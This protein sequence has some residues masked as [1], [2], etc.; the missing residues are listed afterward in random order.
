MNSKSGHLV[1]TETLL[2]ALLGLSVFVGF[3]YGI[4]S[5]PLFDLDEGAFAEATRE[6]FERG[7]FV[8]TYLNGV[9]RY[10]K[11]ILIYWLQAASVAL[12]GVNE[13][14]FRL[15]S[16]LAA[17][18]WVFLVY[19]FVA[20]LRD[21]RTG[22]VAA[23]MVATSLSI[24]VIGKAA[25]ADALLNMLLSASM[26]GAYIYLQDRDRRYLYATF[27]AVGLGFLTKG[28]VAI[29]IPVAVTF[30]YCAVRRELRLWL[31]TVF[32]L[33]GVTL[34]LAIAL[35]WYVLQYLKEGEAFIQGFFLKHNVSRF[36]SPMEGHG[37]GVFYYVPVV[38]F[39]VMPYTTPV[40]K[41]LGRFRAALRDDL[42]LYLLIW[43]VF[44]FAFFSLSGTKLPHYMNYGY[45]G[46]LIL[47]ALSVAELR[48]RFWALLPP[49]VC[50]FALA[51]LPWII[52]WALPRVED[53]FYREGLS[54]AG[55]YFTGGYRAYFFAAIVLTLYFM[56]ERRR[57]IPVKLLAEGI[58]L[59]FGV[60]AFLMPAVARIHQVPVKEA[61]LVAKSRGY[62]VVM[63][64]LNMPSFSVYRRQVTERRAPR[65][66]EVVLTKRERL[67]RLA[68]HEVLYEKNGVVLA[69]LAEAP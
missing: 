18:A 51:G 35:P 20:R 32:D 59:A 23:A 10:D 61:A 25:I 29:L 64:G 36:S 55:A 44:V 22:L 13:L 53:A 15:P 16:A 54:H 43:F 26:F 45:T 38:L 40:L 57:S 5:L 62:E 12:L 3:F 9:P 37:G 6:M 27:A 56:I 41:A 14:A 33:R 17:T 69:R 2:A 46:V 63:W 30:F 65:P 4:G 34:L 19:G 60:A 28:P 68:D 39:G 48:S 50:L 52:Q 7:D 49:L 66:G 11:P 1:S 58:I 31:K 67:P 47:A 8:S 21:T 24:T 42:T